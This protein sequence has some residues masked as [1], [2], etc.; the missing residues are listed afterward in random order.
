MQTLQFTRALA[1]IIK[2]LK[3]QEL[4]TFL[5]P[6]VLRNVA[7]VP[8]SD[9]QKDTFSSLFIASQVGYAHLQEDARTGKIVNSLGIPEL[10]S[11]QRFGRMI[12]HLG[13]LQHSVQTFNAPDIFV[14]FY[15]MYTGL[16]VLV[17][18]DN[19]CK[20]FLEEEKI[21][22]L[23]PGNEFIELRLLDYDGTGIENERVQ[24]FFASLAQLHAILS[25]FLNVSD[26][27][28]IVAY[29]D[30]GSDFLVAF[31]C[32]KALVDI[33]RGLFTEFWEKV[34]FQPFA[35]FERKIGALS[36]G[37]TFVGQVKEQV[38]N[39]AISEADARVLTHRVLAEMTTLVGIGASLPQDEVVETVDNRK[40]LAEKRGIKLLG[41]G[42]DNSTTTS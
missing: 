21:P 38:D 20:T 33:M 5:R 36:T 16:S 35:D 25:Q 41:P 26:S 12:R 10:Y 29:V 31:Q 19:T 22:A 37:L 11:P 24:R 42:N 8:V 9:E 14:D 27:Q 1:T 3:V 28:L 40:L 13:G 34:K 32:A 17:T 23:S 4:V 30:S 39:Q 7:S 6:Y 2:E 15:T 18:V